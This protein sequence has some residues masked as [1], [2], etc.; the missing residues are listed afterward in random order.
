MRLQVWPTRV[1]EDQT[2]LQSLPLNLWFKVVGLD[3]AE[4]LTHGHVQLIQT[5]CPGRHTDTLKISRE[6]LEYSKEY[7]L[8]LGSPSLEEQAEQLAGADGDFNRG[9]VSF[10]HL[11]HVD[12]ETTGQQQRTHFTC[13][14]MNVSRNDT[15][16]LQNV[17]FT[18][19]GNRN[20]PKI[21]N[22]SSELLGGLKSK[23]PLISLGRILK[24]NSLSHVRSWR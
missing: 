9:G 24:L 5:G 23:F 2:G 10:H 6:F 13:K 4:D 8:S 7:L 21:S 12:V 15:I 22:L 16:Y 18:V 1:E 20:L 14:H 11:H 3:G 19:S 17:G